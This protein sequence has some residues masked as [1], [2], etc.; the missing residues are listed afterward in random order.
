MVSE[1]AFVDFKKNQKLFLQEVAAIFKTAV[2]LTNCHSI[3]YSN[4][5]AQGFGINPVSLEE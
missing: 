3:L 5:I 2:I 4:Q 1:F